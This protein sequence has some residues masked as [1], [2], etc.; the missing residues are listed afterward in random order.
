MN[1]SCGFDTSLKEGI[2]NTKHG[3]DSYHKSILG[4]RTFNQS[5]ITNLIEYSI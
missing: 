2:N 5:I 4:E 3:V 1:R